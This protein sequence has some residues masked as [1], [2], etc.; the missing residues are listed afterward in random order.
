MAIRSGAEYRESL[1][2]GRTVF[3]AGERLADVTAYPP[4][5]GVIHSL[6]GLYD[7][8]HERPDEPRTAMRMGSI[9][10]CPSSQRRAPTM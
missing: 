9:S 4:F 7:L 10:P 3:V 6:C 1:Q 8:Q 5:S 2:D